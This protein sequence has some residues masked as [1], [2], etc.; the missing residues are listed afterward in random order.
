MKL[1]CS[2]P[3]LQQNDVDFL[4]LSCNNKF[5]KAC[6]YFI[7]WELSYYLESSNC[8]IIRPPTDR[9]F[10]FILELAR[11]KYT[12]CHIFQ[13]DFLGNETSY[14]KILLHIFALFF[15]VELLYTQLYQ[16]LQTT[17]YK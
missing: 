15:L 5:V 2:L 13:T 10:S 8:L 12:Y 1:R 7:V 9:F 14:D 11:F 6:E 4:G 17:L 3:S 16:W